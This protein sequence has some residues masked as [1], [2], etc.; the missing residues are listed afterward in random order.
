MTKEEF[1]NN[2]IAE[3]KQLMYKDEIFLMSEDEEFAFRK[4]FDK[5][6]EDLKEIANEKGKETI[7][8]AEG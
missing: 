4:F 1:I 3:L 8:K 2:K 7:K 5:F 6:I